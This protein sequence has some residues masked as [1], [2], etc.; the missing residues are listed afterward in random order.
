MQALANL[1]SK[2]EARYVEIGD[3]LYPLN[4]PK[5]LLE[6]LMYSVSP[7]ASLEEKQLNSRCTS[8]DSEV[9]EG[10]VLAREYS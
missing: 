1:L 8:F 6:Q 7:K 3:T 9:L 2:D 5:G 10:M 4:L